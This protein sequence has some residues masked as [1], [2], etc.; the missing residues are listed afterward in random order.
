MYLSASALKHCIYYVLYIFSI[1]KI[2]S[3]RC[4]NAANTVLSFYL[5]L[6]FMICL[7]VVCR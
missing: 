6:V 2:A 7:T 4:C 3:F 5:W 1:G